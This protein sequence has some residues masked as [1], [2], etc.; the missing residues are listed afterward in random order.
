M[1]IAQ[2]AFKRRF[3]LFMKKDGTK[4]TGDHALLA[5]DTLFTVNIIDTV[6]GRDGSGRTVLHAFGNLAL[7]TDNGH[8]YDWVR[9]DHHHADGALLGVVHSETIDG[10]DQFANFTSRTSL[11]HD[12]QLPRHFFL[13][14]ASFS[15]IERL[16][17]YPLFAIASDRRKL[18]NPLGVMPN[19]VQHPVSSY[20][21][22]NLRS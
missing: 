15:P 10:A 1:S 8:S 17:Q 11:W 6:L 12:R 4:R 7:S 20:D 3:D 18:G 19:L 9:V 16:C 22:L 2:I 21:T 13:L 14:S 5:G